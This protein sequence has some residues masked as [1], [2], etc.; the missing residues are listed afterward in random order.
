MTESEIENY[1]KTF[2]IHL[3]EWI[4]DGCPTNHYFSSPYGVCAHL[5]LYMES[6]PENIL[7]DEH[8]EIVDNYLFRNIFN[9]QFTPFNDGDYTYSMDS[10][11]RTMYSNQKRLAFI[12]QQ[13][14]K[15][16]K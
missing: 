9:K 7:S 5:N 1:L 14:T 11:N 12:K 8:S 13:A 6:Y 15:E 3:Q 2:F 10:D 16:I 4:D